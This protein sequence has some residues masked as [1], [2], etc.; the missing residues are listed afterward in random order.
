[1]KHTNWREI[2]EI[3][4]ILSIVASLL[5][6]ATELRQSNRIALADVRLEIIENYNQ[7]HFE[8]ASNPEFA[9]L[10]AKLE[11]P[12]AHLITATERQQIKGLVR[13]YMNN[14]IYVHVAHEQGFLTDVEIAGHATRFRQVLEGLP[15]IMPAAVAHFQSAPGVQH[16]PIFAVLKDAASAAPVEDSTNRP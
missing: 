12:G 7:L 5:L 6:L 15:G 2:V 4:G 8:R 1:M 3:I 10:Y 16:Y 14:A 11:D 9:K 13:Q